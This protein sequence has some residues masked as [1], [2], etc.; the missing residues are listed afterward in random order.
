MPQDEIALMREISNKIFQNQLEQRAFKI[1]LSEII[2]REL[3]QDD[4]ALLDKTLGK[5]GEISL[6]NYEEQAQQL[7]AAMRA[8]MQREDEARAEASERESA[9]FGSRSF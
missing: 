5:H 1:L 4:Q 6:G 3:N 9:E 8:A 7:V 2:E